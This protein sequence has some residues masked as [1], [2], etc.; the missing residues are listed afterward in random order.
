V[1]SKDVVRLP[2]DTVPIALASNNVQLG[3][4]DQSSV[5]IRNP[6]ETLGLQVLER[7]SFRVEPELPLPKIGKEIRVFTPTL[8]IF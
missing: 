3:L 6:K 5:S 8:P 7:L 4:P 2:A 1:S